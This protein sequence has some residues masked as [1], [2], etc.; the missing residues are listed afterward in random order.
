M[1]NGNNYFSPSFSSESALPEFGSWFDDEL[2]RERELVKQISQLED[3]QIAHAISSINPSDK[4]SAFYKYREYLEGK[5][6]PS[7]AR[8]KWILKILQ[9]RQWISWEDFVR[10]ISQPYASIVTEVEEIVWK[11]LQSNQTK[12]ISYPNNWSKTLRQ[13][14]EENW[15][16]H[17]NL[18]IRCFY[19]N[20]GIEKVRASG[21]DRANTHGFR[22]HWWYD[23]EELACWLHWLPHWET[24]YVVKVNDSMLDRSLSK[25]Q[26][27]DTFLIYDANGLDPIWPLW[28]PY[29]NWFAGFLTP[30]LMKK[31]LLAVI[32]D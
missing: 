31:S 9:K 18:F 25:N 26:F 2:R 17:E 11:H 22:N 28:F 32:W 30:W 5:N 24:T 16:S 4:E 20:S 14:L 10:L 19:K 29:S 3:K 15:I 8:I 27:G 1:N 23:W 13:I 21:S 7:E 6:E 12:H